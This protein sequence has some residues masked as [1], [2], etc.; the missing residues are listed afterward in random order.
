MSEDVEILVLDPDGSEGPSEF[1]FTGKAIKPE[2][3][4]E[5]LAAL[6]TALRAALREKLPQDVGSDVGLGLNEIEVS[7]AI[8]AAGNLGIVKGSATGTIA[9]RFTRPTS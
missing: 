8:S 4:A 2:E 5:Q 3:I 9:L 7:V 1:A 6:A